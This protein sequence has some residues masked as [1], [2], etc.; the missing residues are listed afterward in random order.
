MS[1]FGPFEIGSTLSSVLLG[2][3]TLQ[4]WNYFLNFPNDPIII[5][6]MVAVV[7]F[8]D[9][10]QSAFFA[11]TVYWFTIIGTEDGLA[12]NDIHV[13]TTMPWTLEASVALFAFVNFTVQT[14][15]CHQVNYISRNIYIALGCFFLALVRLGL[16]LSILGPMSSNNT[17]LVVDTPTFKWEIISELAV[18]TAADVLIAMCMCIGLRGKRTGFSHSDRLVDRLV[19]FALATGVMT[20]VVSIVQ[21]ATYATMPTSFVWVACFSLTSK[22]F[23]NSLLASLNRRRSAGAATPVSVDRTV[24]VEIQ[25]HIEMTYMKDSSQSDVSGTIMTGSRDSC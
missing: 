21:V 25:R 8:T 7:Y 18:G 24:R 3:S 1:S 22:L 12:S 10:L 5:K 11:H 15:F 9:V 14:Y 2:I 20:S 6:S 19:S 23:T 13:L 4:A 17:L 16:T